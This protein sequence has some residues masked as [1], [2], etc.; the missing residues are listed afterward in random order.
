MISSNDMSLRYITD[1][2]QKPAYSSDN[3]TN[4]LQFKKNLNMKDDLIMTQYF[5][6]GKRNKWDYNDATLLC[7]LK[8]LILCNIFK[9][10]LAY[11]I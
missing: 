10:Y 4:N 7:C 9:D 6:D 8:I 3:S 5:S 11:P 1:E 2:L